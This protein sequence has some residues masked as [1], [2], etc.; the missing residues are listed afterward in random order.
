[1]GTCSGVCVACVCMVPIIG[2]ERGRVHHPYAGL[3]VQPVY[4]NAGCATS[5]HDPKHMVKRWIV[6]NLWGCAHNL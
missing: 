1:M 5:T 2:S 4:K 3:S 6:C